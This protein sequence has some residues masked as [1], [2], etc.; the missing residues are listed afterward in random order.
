[1]TLAVA[2]TSELYEWAR[3]FTETAAVAVRLAGSAFVPASLRVLDRNEVIDMEATAAN[4]TSAILTGRELGLP[5]MAALR[6]IDVVNGTPALRALALRALVL[7]AGHSIYVVESTT[8]RAVVSGQR[9]EPGAK[10]QTSTWTIDRARTANLA[11]KPNWRTNAPAM[12]VARATGECARWIA[13]EELLGVPYSA[14]ELADES[15]PSV[16]AVAPVAAATGP[17]IAPEALPTEE[18]EAKPKRAYR[19]QRPVKSV[20][21]PPPPAEPAAPD[22]APETAGA[23]TPPVAPV[24]NRPEAEPNEMIT[25]AQLG[26]LMAS[27]RAL[28]VED[29]DERL[30]MAQTIV[31]RQIESS[32]QLTKTEASRVIDELMALAARETAMRGLGATD[33]DPWPF[34]DDMAGRGEG[35]DDEPPN[36]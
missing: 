6:S 15:L 14:E 7:R 22:V 36:D 33:L 23:A 21:L 35:A 31:G 2:E 3:A 29:R 5:P 4:I 13:P 1:M 19:R 10:V 24:D 25:S 11:N 28:R 26:A 34:G 30:R 32:K 20:E 9:K 17:A 27:F 8:T 16:E 18:T 12:L